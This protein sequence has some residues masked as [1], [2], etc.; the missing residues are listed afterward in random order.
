MKKVDFIGED[1]KFISKAGEHFLPGEVECEGDFSTWNP[2]KKV[3]SGWG[4]FRGLT[5]ETYAGYIG[6]LPR[7]DGDTCSFSEFNIL[8]RGVDVSEWTYEELLGLVEAENRD[9]KIEKVLVNEPNRT[10]TK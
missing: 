2:Q 8:Y 7:P 4:M 5:M 3:N 9:K 10:I 6:Q 1:F